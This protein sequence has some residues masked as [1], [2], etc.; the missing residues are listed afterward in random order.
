MLC[1][2]FSGAGIGPQ[3][4]IRRTWT[5]PTHHSNHSG[6][7]LYPREVHWRGLRKHPTPCAHATWRGTTGA[8]GVHLWCLGSGCARACHLGPSSLVGVRTKR[9]NKQRRWGVPSPT[10]CPSPPDEAE[11]VQTHRSHLP[12][13]QIAASA[14]NASMGDKSLARN[15]LDKYWHDESCKL[16]WITLK[17]N[18]QFQQYLLRDRGYVQHIPAW[19]IIVY[20]NQT[21]KL[22]FAIVTKC[23]KSLTYRFYVLWLLIHVL[24][25]LFA[26]D[27]PLWG[28]ASPHPAPPPTKAVCTTCGDNTSVTPS[29]TANC[30]ECCAASSALHVG[31][32][33]LP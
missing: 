1:P 32:T 25:F 17:Y 24:F 19:D 12:R 14:G 20:H 26:G 11:S 6:V 18:T 9:K 30:W 5:H 31:R 29:T 4:Y 27:S 7:A 10:E 3:G 22:Q 13:R 15:K 28:A 23:F 33:G 21:S 2:S 16:D 8:G